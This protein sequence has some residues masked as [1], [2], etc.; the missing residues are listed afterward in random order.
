MK[1]SYEITVVLR[2]DNNEDVQKSNLEQVKTWVESNGKGVINKI[3][4]TH[5]G[6]RRLAYEINGQR[7]GLYVLFYAD[8][9]A[10]AIE[11]LDRNFRLASGVL[12][13][14]IVRPD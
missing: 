1:K 7:E 4:T 8:V 9:D 6:R 3:D 11:E 14:L 10:D 12:R 13:H 5:W 2:V